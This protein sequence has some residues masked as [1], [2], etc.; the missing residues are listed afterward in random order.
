LEKSLLTKAEKQVTTQ[1]PEA[2]ERPERLIYIG[3]NLPGGKLSKYAIY[4]GGLP[5]HLNDVYE[6]CP[7]IKK[8]FVEPSSMAKKEQAIQQKGTPESVFYSQ[9]LDYSKKGGGQ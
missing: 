2:N 9:V 3:P 7:A 1:T 5:T 8:L 4:K 6:A